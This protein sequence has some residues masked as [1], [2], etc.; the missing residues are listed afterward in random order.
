MQFVELIEVITRVI[1]RIKKVPPNEKGVFLNAGHF[2][3][4][5]EEGIYVFWPLIQDI[6][7]IDV[8][9]QVINLP[10]QSVTT[11]DQKTVAIGGAIEYS[12]GNV[13]K[14][15]L[16]VQDYDT[17]LQNLAMGIIADFVMTHTFDECIKSD[18]LK[19]EVT[20]GIRHRATD[21]G[22]RIRKFYLTDLAEH[23]VHRVMTQDQPQTNILPVNTYQ[24]EE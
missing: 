3:R 15:I 12:I 19:K 21:W 24:A 8:T 17:S 18:Q 16:E 10:N 7:T 11:N 13:Q 6:L 20:D 1:P 23:Q 14:A 5:V 22:L 9:P 4:D 2:R